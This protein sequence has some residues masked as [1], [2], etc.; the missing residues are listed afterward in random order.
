MEQR[1]ISYRTGNYSKYVLTRIESPAPIQENDLESVCY[2]T[3]KVLEL[4]LK[5]NFRIWT[6]TV[7]GI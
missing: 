5:K 7:I 6:G 2:D 1:G 4:I 3:A